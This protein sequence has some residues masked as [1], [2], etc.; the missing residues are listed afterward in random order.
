MEKNR[1]ILENIDKIIGVADINLKK[2]LS[3]KR[4]MSLILILKILLVK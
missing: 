1:Y 3:L 2:I 4:K